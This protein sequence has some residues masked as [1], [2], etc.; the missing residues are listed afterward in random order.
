[1]EIVC[2]EY[3]L[4]LFLLCAIFVWSLHIFVRVKWIVMKLCTYGTCLFDARRNF[5]TFR[6]G[7]WCILWIPDEQRLVHVQALRA[8]YCVWDV[9]L[10]FCGCLHSVQRGFAPVYLCELGNEVPLLNDSVGHYFLLLVRTMEQRRQSATL[11][12]SFCFQCGG[13]QLKV[14]KKNDRW[15]EQ[16]WFTTV[17]FESLMLESR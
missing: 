3:I 15:R 5:W 17:V 12:F 13:V 7:E 1:M 10:W 11:F 9:V 6:S 16:M 4:V 8:L 14:G 2:Q